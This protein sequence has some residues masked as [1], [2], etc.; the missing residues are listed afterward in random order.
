[1]VDDSR[2]IMSLDKIVRGRRVFYM[3]L[4]ALPDPA[5]GG[6]LGAILLADLAALAG[7][8]YNLDAPEPRSS[9]FVDEVADVI[10]QP[11][12]QILNK[13]AESGITTTCA[14]QTLADLA[15]RLGSDD[16]AR[17]AVGNLNN[18]FALRSK[19]RPTQDFIVETFGKTPIHSVDVSIGT[20]TPA[21]WPDFSGSRLASVARNERGDHSRGHPGQAA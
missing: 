16:A 21:R 17:K 13:G 19:D 12:I 4:D 6:A 5:V 18:L 3:A 11:L 15:D 14:M 1:M 9:L 2:P 20:H 10:N 8:R 7:I